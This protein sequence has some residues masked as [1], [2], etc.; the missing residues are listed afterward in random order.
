VA[1]HNA[2]NTRIKR[3]Y[4]QYLREARG[5]SPASVDAAAKAISR[6][7]ESANHRDFASFHREQAVAFKR[8]LAEQLGE[9]SGKPLSQSTIGG[10]LRALREFFIWLAGQPGYKAKI[11][12]AD[13]DYFNQSDKEQ[14]VAW[15]ARPKA[16]PTLEQMRHILGTMPAGTP[17]ERRN[18]AVVALTMLTGARDGA[19]ASLRLK[20]LDLA[21]G[22]L[23]QDGREVRTK[24]AKTFST[25]FFPVGGDALSIVTDW[26][27]WLRERHW[28]DADPLFPATQVGLGE[29]GGFVAEGLARTG[30]S[31][32]APIRTIFREACAAAQMRY[33]N[34]H[35]LRDMLA[36]LG[37][38]VCQTPEQFKAWS[39]NLGHE[40]VLTTLMSYGAV[41]PHRQAQLIRA[42][43]TPPDRATVTPEEVSALKA[44]LEKM[45]AQGFRSGD[46][47]RNEGGN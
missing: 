8:K 46:A 41:P 24:F 34:P 31:T 17:I 2:K 44:L 23:W 45:T 28:G 35:S 26:V 43:A 19:L 7:E 5:Y 11:R 10:T 37:E 1:K 14:A 38:Q 15:A 9:R 27:G 22:V 39:Q 20:H 18:R 6:F 25:W 42:L 21:E 40:K 47:V 13:A 29:N 36:Q 12:Y 33:F 4:F 32:A 16:P 3:E 30:W